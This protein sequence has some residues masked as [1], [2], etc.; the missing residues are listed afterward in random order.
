MNSS[1]SFAKRPSVAVPAE[2]ASFAIPDQRDSCGKSD[3]PCL[4]TLPIHLFPPVEP[5]DTRLAAT[6]TAFRARASWANPTLSGPLQ[7]WLHDRRSLVEAITQRRRWP[8]K[9]R[10]AGN[11]VPS[12]IG[13]HRPGSCRPLQ[14]L[15]RLQIEDPLGEPLGPQDQDALY[16]SS[17]RS[18]GTVKNSATATIHSIAT[19]MAAQNSCRTRDPMPTR[20]IAA[21][22]TPSARNPA[23]YRLPRPFLPSESSE[24]ISADPDTERKDNR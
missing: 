15:V 9:W 2:P 8:R 10:I 17:T 11:V 5:C 20:T 1:V 3:P 12:Q 4:G 23:S 13:P 22:G 19:R 14:E 6:A 7:A 21:I 24:A 18:G 16:H